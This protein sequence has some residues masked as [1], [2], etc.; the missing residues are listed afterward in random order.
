MTQSTGAGKGILFVLSAPSGAGKTTVAELVLSSVPD[1]DRSIS[2]TTRQIRAGETDEVDYHFVDEQT[3]KKMLENGEFIEWANVY[4]AMYGTSFKTV[5]KVL[6]KAE[7][8]LLLV[9]DVQGA[10]TL[11]NKEVISRSIFLVPP[12]ME[13]L[14]KRLTDRGTES[15]DKLQTRL[16]AARNEMEQRGKFDHIIVNDDLDVAV[17]DVVAVINAER[18]LQK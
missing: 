5:E 1:L 4:G 10:E 8:D 2:H 3:F 12:S 15:Q 17:K 7:S 6:S 18:A 13:E 16:E 14:E 11:R 9:I